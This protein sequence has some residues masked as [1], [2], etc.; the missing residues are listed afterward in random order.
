MV[1]FLISFRVTEREEFAPVVSI[2]IPS[3]RR[4]DERGADL[5]DLVLS[6]VVSPHN[7]RDP[8]IVND[9][10]VKSYLTVF[11]HSR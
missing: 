3:D 10:V 11:Q 4:N 9:E 7:I 8:L 1:L 5:N 6:V 2:A